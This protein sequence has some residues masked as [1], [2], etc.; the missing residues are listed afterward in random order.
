MAS[1]E[2]LVTQYVTRTILV[3]VNADSPEAAIA[4]GIKIARPIQ[5]ADWDLHDGPVHAEGKV[6]EPLSATRVVTVPAHSRP[7]N[8]TK[9]LTA[10]EVLQIAD[11]AYEGGE[12]RISELVSVGERGDS[13]AD[14]LANELRDVLKDDDDPTHAAIRALQTAKDQIDNV[15]GALLAHR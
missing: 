13:L 2:I 4:E 8:G 7:A 15:I 14:F 10:S 1:Y 3:T 6:I 11:E 9:T 5:D 12:M